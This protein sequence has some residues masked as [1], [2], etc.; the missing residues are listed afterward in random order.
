[1]TI[2][3]LLCRYFTSMAVCV[4]VEGN[5]GGGTE[6]RFRHRRLRRLGEQAFLLHD[7]RQVSAAGD[8]DPDDGLRQVPLQPAGLRHPRLDRSAAAARYGPVQRLVRRGRRR[9]GACG[10]AADGRQFP[11]AVDHV[12][13]VRAEGGRRPPVAA[14]PRHSQHAHRAGAAGVPDA[15]GCRHVGG[16]VQHRAVRHA[17]SGR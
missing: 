7:A 1:M 16:E 3:L 9:L 10:R 17:A 14:A 2:T 4:G 12:L 13:V 8:A 15:Q 11:T 6:T 5:C